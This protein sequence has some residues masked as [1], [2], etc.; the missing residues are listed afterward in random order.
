[1]GQTNVLEESE[2]VFVAGAAHITSVHFH[3][4]VR[5]QVSGEGA[6][7][8]EAGTTKVA[9]IRAVFTVFGFGGWF[10]FGLRLRIFLMKHK[11]VFGK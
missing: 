2:T 10:C 6:F 1:M 11:I 3:V 5:H 8:A 7:D 9:N 4:G